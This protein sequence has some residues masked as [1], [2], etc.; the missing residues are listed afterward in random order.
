MV[1]YILNSLFSYR[2][3]NVESPEGSP[4]G[5]GASSSKGGSSEAGTSGG[6]GGGGGTSTSL[7]SMNAGGN[8]YPQS[9]QLQITTLQQH[10][11]QDKFT[12]PKLIDWPPYD[13]LFKKYL[14]IGMSLPCSLNTIIFMSYLFL[15]MS[16]EVYGILV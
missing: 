5:F 12:K 7:S 14:S 13:T 8:R 6:G 3:P 11:N 1:K 4:H 10:T 9:P 15:C 2:N 16:Y